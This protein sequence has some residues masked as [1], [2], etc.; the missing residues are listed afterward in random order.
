M[1]GEEEKLGALLGFAAG[2]ELSQLLSCL[3]S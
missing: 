3:L 2:I 1:A